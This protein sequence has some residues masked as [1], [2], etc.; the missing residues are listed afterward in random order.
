M[1]LPMQ[2]AAPPA[3]PPSTG[4]PATGGIP[5]APNTT[6]NPAKTALLENLRQ[7]PVNLNTATLP[8]LDQIPEIGP[9]MGQRILDDRA[10]NGPFHTVDDLSRIKGIK[11]KTLD[12]IRPYVVVQ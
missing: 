2:P 4:A 6:P 5:T 10:T 12:A 11:G 8:Q 7:N 3:I 1:T 9:K